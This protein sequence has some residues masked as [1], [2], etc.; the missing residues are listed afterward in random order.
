MITAGTESH[1]PVSIIDLDRCVARV[2]AAYAK[3]RDLKLEKQRE[4]VK[5]ILNSAG[6]DHN[7][8]PTRTLQL[9]VFFFSRCV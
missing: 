8:G 2:S 1:W 5:E 4:D 6:V 3:H 7:D 9:L